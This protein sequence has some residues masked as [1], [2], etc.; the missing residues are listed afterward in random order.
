MAKVVSTKRAL[1][2]L[3]DIGDYISKDSVKYAKFTLEKLVDSASLIGINPILGRLVPEANDKSIRELL[4]GNYRVIYQIRR[5]N[6]VFILTVF[7]TSRLLTM[8]DLE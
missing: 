2:D 3:E 4:K 7:H 8:K 1:H 6:A 5:N